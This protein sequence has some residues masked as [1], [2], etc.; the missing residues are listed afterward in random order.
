MYVVSEHDE[1]ILTIE[2]E[3]LAALLSA[4]QEL[5]D[6]LRVYE[7]LERVKI[8]RD[9]ERRSK[10]ETRMDPRVSEQSIIDVNLLLMVCNL[11]S[12][13]HQSNILA[14]LALLDVL[15]LLMSRT[16]LLR[17]LH[18]RLLPRHLSPS[19]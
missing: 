14:A 8:E 6:A 12:K 3:L 10:K 7:D 11:S 17:R 13:N 4:N 18:H 19:L 5:T 15:S 16:D 2:E 9:T 1:R